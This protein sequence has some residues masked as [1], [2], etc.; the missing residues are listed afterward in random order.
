VCEK[1]ARNVVHQVEER[2]YT[3]VHDGVVHSGW[4]RH[5]CHSLF[6]HVECLSAKQRTLSAPR[7]PLES[8]SIK[9]A[10]L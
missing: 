3:F 10:A 2:Y 1:D 4:S 6:G 8:P 9:N 7:N 5:E